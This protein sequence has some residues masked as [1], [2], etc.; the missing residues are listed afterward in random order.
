MLAYV[1]GEELLSEIS[2][3]SIEELTEALNEIVE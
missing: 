1:W 2:A 3:E